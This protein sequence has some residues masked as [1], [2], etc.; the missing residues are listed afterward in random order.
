M[1]YE[2]AKV[3]GGTR[4]CTYKDIDMYGGRMRRMTD[5]QLI[6]TFGKKPF[7]THPYAAFENNGQ[8][9][10]FDEP[11]NIFSC[12]IPT[13]IPKDRCVT[14]GGNKYLGMPICVRPTSIT[15]EEKKLQSDYQKKKNLEI[16]T[17]RKE[18]KSE[19]VMIN[20]MVGGSSSLDK[21]YSKTNR[22][23]FEAL[24]CLICIECRNAIEFGGFLEP[25]FGLNLLP[26]EVRGLD[27]NKFQRRTFP[28]GHV[29]LPDQE[30]K[31]LEVKYWTDRILWFSNPHTVDATPIQRQIIFE[32]LG[33]IIKNNKNYVLIGSNKVK[34]L[35]IGRV[36]A[37]LLHTL[38][39]LMVRKYNG[40]EKVSKDKFLFLMHAVQNV[41]ACVKNILTPAI[42][43]E[44]KIMLI[45]WMCRKETENMFEHFS[46]PLFIASFIGN[47]QCVNYF[48]MCK[49]IKLMINE[50]GMEHFDKDL[51]AGNRELALL[52][53][54]NGHVVNLANEMF[55]TKMLIG[56]M[57]KDFTNPQVIEELYKE[58]SVVHNTT[59]LCSEYKDKVTPGL[60]AVLGLCGSMVKEKELG[61]II[62]FIKKTHRRQLAVVAD[63]IRTLVPD[64][65]TTFK[66]ST[67]VQTSTKATEDL[68]DKERKKHYGLPPLLHGRPAKLGHKECAYCG[69]TFPD[70]I[71]L[72][73][74][75]EFMF[76][77]NAEDP[78]F[79]EQESHRIACSL[80][81]KFD[82][83]PRS[84]TG[85]KDLKMT[86]QK[87][88]D[89]NITTCPVIGCVFETTTTTD[90]MKHF[91][92]QVETF[93]VVH[94]PVKKGEKKQKPIKSEKI[95]EEKVVAD[96]DTDCR[97]CMDQDYSTMFLPCGHVCSCS[98]CAKKLK[99]CPICR[100]QIKAIFPLKDV[101]Q[102][103]QK[104][105]AYK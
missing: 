8:V 95:S 28:V 12:I 51:A 86:A 78:R 90:M 10:F 22:L 83:G 94:V 84:I 96:E 27:S 3:T 4:P 68:L 47:A 73:R 54:Y 43:D 23:V 67:A 52:R 45:K 38:V 81:S 58:L 33:L 48:Q 70:K 61:Y 34:A 1:S 5:S 15:D 36:F 104:E 30:Q 97:I 75:L 9:I 79:N 40:T 11:G 39:A 55:F 93:E 85:Q 41:Y 25:F 17:T 88:I 24:P 7:H 82:F 35:A 92:S 105:H 56:M 59:S 74:H 21:D 29:L 2:G 53:L 101:P 49:L 19:L 71:K 76:G 65:K 16:K 64:I 6:E 46:A 57:D 42:A 89:E 69:V 60:F 31:T 98:E 62:T 72:I 37:S 99:K 103:V 44:I 20:P 87:I 14:C 102:I 26:K 13:K 66:V 91:A 32:Q 63:D 50:R 18:R 77:Y 100:T 80:G